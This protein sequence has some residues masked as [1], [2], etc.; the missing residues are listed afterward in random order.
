MSMAIYIATTGTTT[1]GTTRFFESRSMRATIKHEL[2][3]AVVGDVLGRLF[4]KRRMPSRALL[5][6]GVVCEL[7]LCGRGVDVETFLPIMLQYRN[8]HDVRSFQKL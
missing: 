1:F 5:L 7:T 8:A 2:G 6:P 3:H 4:R